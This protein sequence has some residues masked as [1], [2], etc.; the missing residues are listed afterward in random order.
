MQ[1][2]WQKMYFTVC[3]LYKYYIV[4]LWY[5]HVYWCN[6]VNGQQGSGFWRTD[7]SRTLKGTDV[8]FDLW[9]VITP[10]NPYFTWFQS[11]DVGLP[12]VCLLENFYL[13]RKCHFVPFKDLFQ[14]CCH[15]WVLLNC[16][17]FMCLGINARSY[18]IL[19][20]PKIGIDVWMIVK[21]FLN[22]AVEFS[23]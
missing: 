20:R 17:K 1:V 19:L 23:H 18:C 7:G 10:L 15:C 2:D 14:W 12:D 21:V 13:E 11:I 22:T 4:Y 8:L 6:L 16:T 3:I 5:A 9:W